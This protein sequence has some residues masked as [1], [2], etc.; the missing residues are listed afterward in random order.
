MQS[1]VVA[2]LGAFPPPVFPRQQSLKRVGD[3][4]QRNTSDTVLPSTLAKAGEPQLSPVP[5]SPM[6]GA[7]QCEPEYPTF[8]AR[9]GAAV[10]DNH[11]NSVE[12]NSASVVK[13]SEPEVLPKLSPKMRRK[14][15]SPSVS[16]I[17]KKNACVPLQLDGGTEGGQLNGHLTGVDVHP[18]GDVPAIP[19]KRKSKRVIIPEEDVEFELE[20]VPMPPLHVDGKVGG[21]AREDGVPSLPP[22][23]VGVPNFTNESGVESGT[24]NVPMI[25][26]SPQVTNQSAADSSVPPLPSKDSGSHNVAPPLPTRDVLQEEGPETPMAPPLPPRDAGPPDFA[27]PPPPRQVTPEPRVAVARGLPPPPPPR[28]STL[29]RDADEKEVVDVPLLPPKD[30]G[31]PQFKPLSPPDSLNDFK[32]ESDVP[33]VLPHKEFPPLVLNRPSPPPPLPPKEVQLPPPPPPITDEDFPQEDVG[34]SVSEDEEEDDGAPL[35]SIQSQSSHVVQDEIFILAQSPENERERRSL[36]SDAS[37]PEP[38]PTVSLIWQQKSQEG[39]DDMV[40]FTSNPATNVDYENQDVVDET[41]R[42][43]NPDYA[44]QDAIDKSVQRVNEAMLGKNHDYANQDAIDQSVQ[45]VDEAML[46]KNQDYA[47]QDAIDESIQIKGTAPIRARSLKRNTDNDYENQDV[48]DEDIIP[49]GTLLEPVPSASPSTKLHRQE[50]MG[51]VDL[52]PPSRSKLFGGY[53]DVDRD[54]ENTRDDVPNTDAVLPPIPPK[55]STLGAIDVSRSHAAPKGSEIDFNTGQL[56]PPKSTTLAANSVPN[57]P[58]PKP[59]SKTTAAI[60]L[61]PVIFEEDLTPRGK[62]SGSENT[63]SSTTPASTPD[64]M[65]SSLMDTGHGPPAVPPPY[66]SHSDMAHIAPPVPEPYASSAPKHSAGDYF[67]GQVRCWPS[68]ISIHDERTIRID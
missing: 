68:D 54:Y 40:L 39:T 21:I 58:V 59:R 27:P 57:R 60:I 6:S 65:Y 24:T 44:N 47:N 30:S 53:E 63:S 50:E 19:P 64:S 22:R 11:S 42:D 26:V 62:L 55:A 18:V 23:G 48:L 35:I 36:S 8:H 38:A 2:E 51:H 45:R 17:K 9:N 67:D 20:N 7:M 5:Q 15:D 4:L 49:F 13:D 56:P 43:K 28:T 66:G 12:A 31:V 3:G 33:P 37:S 25:H 61:T 34:F 29:K 1:P 32:S 52:K 41:M 46:D 10:M 16:P 14:H